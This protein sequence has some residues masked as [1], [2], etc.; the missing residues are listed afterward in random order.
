MCPWTH[1]MI[2]ALK[3]KK[4][5]SDLLLILCCPCFL[6]LCFDLTPPFGL[7]C[8][9]NLHSSLL[10]FSFLTLHIIL[11]SAFISL[12]AVS[13]P[14]PHHSPDPLFFPCHYSLL[15][16]HPSIQ[17]III[18]FITPLPLFLPLPP[19]HSSFIRYPPACSGWIPGAWVGTPRQCLLRQAAA[20][21]APVWVVQPSEL[22]AAGQRPGFY[23]LRHQVHRAGQPRGLLGWLPERSPAGGPK[24]GFHYWLPEDGS[25][26]GG[27]PPADQCGPGW[28][29]GRPK[30]PES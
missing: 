14:C 9:S 15:F 5:W 10:R 24:G 19:P 23:R 22:S 11:L 28:L 3:C 2:T 29:W 16:L 25:R 8:G 30:A 27:C 21:G 13:L 12:L 6:S 17:T 20:P 1:H 4:K 7:W 18:T 26:S